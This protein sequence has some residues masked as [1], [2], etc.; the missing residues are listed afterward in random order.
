[1]AVQ[2]RGADSL[3][4]KNNGNLQSQT[5]CGDNNSENNN[6]IFLIITYFSDTILSITCIY[7]LIKFSCI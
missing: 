2:L 7:L 3:P 1:M 5:N 4:L 6:N